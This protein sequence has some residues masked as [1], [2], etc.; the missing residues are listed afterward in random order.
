MPTSDMS[1]YNEADGSLRHSQ[2]QEVKQTAQAR[3]QGPP[4]TCWCSWSAVK[5]VAQPIGRYSACI[6]G[7]PQ[8]INAVSNLSQRSDVP[9]DT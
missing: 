9:A 5:S 8:H 3:A 1:C 7:A 2:R 4:P 6:V